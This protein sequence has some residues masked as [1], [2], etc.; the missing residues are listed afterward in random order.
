M[1][2]LCSMLISSQ[3]LPPLWLHPTT[4]RIF[5]ILK[6]GGVLTQ[7]KIAQEAQISHVHAGR[8]LFELQKDNIAFHKTVGKAHL[9]ELNHESYASK[10]LLRIQ[11]F[12]ESLPT[13][14]E[15]LQ[16]MILESISKTSIAHI[17]LFGSI[18]KG[19][20]KENSDIDLCIILKPKISHQD[21]SINNWITHLESR[22]L[23]M[24]GRRLE[25]HLFT[26]TEWT[27]KS[28]TPMGTQILQGLKIL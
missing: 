14:L 8:I 12:I 18:I 19:D 25:V 20:E 11:S 9:W 10:T 3:A 22:V 7:R 23:E 4:L 13:P 2:E 16:S 24:F 1:E 17:Y 21:P 28:L 26:S 5:N 15:I 27:K 6:K